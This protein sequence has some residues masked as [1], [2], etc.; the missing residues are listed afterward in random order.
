MLSFV[1]GLIKWNHMQGKQFREPFIQTSA[2][3]DHF[4]FPV[5]KTNNVLYLCLSNYIFKRFL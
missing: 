5:S 4:I 3:T 1:P 2:F